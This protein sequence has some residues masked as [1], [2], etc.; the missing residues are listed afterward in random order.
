MGLDVLPVYKEKF[1]LNG[2]MIDYRSE[3]KLY[4]ILSLTQLHGE[5]HADQLGVSM[6]QNA[7]HDVFF[8]LM[9][10]RIDIARNPSPFTFIDAET[11]PGKAKRAIFPRF[12]RFFDDEGNLLVSVST[13]WMLCSITDRS[14]IR[15]ESVL[16]AMPE[17]IYENL[18]LP[19]KLRFAFDEYSS[20]EHF[21]SYSDLD[22]YGHVNNRKYVEWCCDIFPQKKF[23]EYRII[24]FQINYVSEIKY[25]ETV[26]INLR[27]DGESFY[28]EGVRKSDNARAFLA[29]GE[30]AKR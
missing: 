27:V 8:I 2:N 3:M 9:R 25:G 10:Q 5:M 22:C 26:I 11:W 18:E 1:L 17:P 29:G 21:V 23:D 24:K 13:L 14:I 16:E 19:E 12:H 7:K 6:N 15:D 28:I 20:S 4:D 30:W